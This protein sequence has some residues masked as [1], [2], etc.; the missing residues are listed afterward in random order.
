MRG[1]GLGGEKTERSVIVIS[2]YF[3]RK[4]CGEAV[5]AKIDLESRSS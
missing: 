3:A 5:R 4:D 2:V 1:S